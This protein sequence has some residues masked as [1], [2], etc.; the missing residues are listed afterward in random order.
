MYLYLANQRTLW[1]G[2][3][4][5]YSCRKEIGL[6]TIKAILA[7]TPSCIVSGV[8]VVKKISVSYHRKYKVCLHKLKEELFFIEPEKKK[9]KFV[10]FFHWPEIPFLKV[11]LFL[12]TLVNFYKGFKHRG[13]PLPPWRFTVHISILNILGSPEFNTVWLISTNFLV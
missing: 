9:D 1:L 5:F 3:L 7:P 11:F 4:C 10:V 12:W 2:H 13:L 6:E 8:V